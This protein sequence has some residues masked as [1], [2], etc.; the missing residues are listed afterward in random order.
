[1]LPIFFIHF[2]TREPPCSG[3]S[4]PKFF[5][6]VKWNNCSK[7]I[8]TRHNFTSNHIKEMKNKTFLF[9]ADEDSSESPEIPS[10]RST[11]KFGG[12]PRGVSQSFSVPLNLFALV[13]SESKSSSS[14][15]SDNQSSSLHLPPPSE[16]EWVK[17]FLKAGSFFNITW[18][19]GRG[20]VLRDVEFFPWVL[21]FFL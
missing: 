17:I 19:G 16:T 9:F 13:R 6:S 10:I 21:S 15:S 18:E 20:Q 3:N 5:I 12:G 8:S 2:V 14:S 1:M 4:S 11:K 7:H